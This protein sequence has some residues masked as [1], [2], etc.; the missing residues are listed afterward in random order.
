MLLSASLHLLVCLY[1]A[2][3]FG[4]PDIANM[5]NILGI[6]LLFPALGHGAINC[7]LGIFMVIAIGI[8]F[9]GMQQWHDRHPNSRRKATKR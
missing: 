6:S 5:F 8:W 7:L 9:Y 4:N 3:R 1:N 2:V